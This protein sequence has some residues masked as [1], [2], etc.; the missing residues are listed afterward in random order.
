M[1]DSRWIE[2][3][4]YV[5][6]IMRR[7]HI[8]GAAVAV[9]REGEVLYK[10]GFGM[11]DMS[12]GAPV[13]PDTIFGI[14]SV[15]KSFTGLAIMRLQ[16]EGEL[17]SEDA[18]IRHL[19]DLRIRNMPDMR[20]VKVRHILS[21]TTGLSPVRRREEIT[22]FAEH[23]EYLAS[24]DCRIL[25]RPGDHFSYC[26]DTFMLNGALI[27]R[28]TGHRYR[29]HMMEALV[30]AF[31]LPRTTYD[32][33][34]L[35]SF[36]NVT[37]PYVYNK[38]TGQHEQK[39]YPSLGTYEVGGGVRSCVTALLRYGAL[40]VNGGVL[41]GERVLSE[42]ALRQMRSPVY[43]ISRKA[44]YC[45]ALETVPDYE[46][47]TLVFHGGSQPG[48]SAHFGFIPEKRLVAAVLTNVTGVPAKAI[49]LGAVNAALDLPVRQQY[50]TEPQYTATVAELERLAGS[51][52][53]D[54][55][56]KFVVAVE[57]GIPFIEVEGEPHR[58]RAS[59]E[60]TLVYE[61]NGFEAPVRFFF[62]DAGEVW[63]AR[64]GVRMHWKER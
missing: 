10:N 11:R 38:V 44:H 45:F 30:K 12:T 47:N 5:K 1:Q 32:I 37:V 64:L 4:D 19:P 31:G 53:N 29:A 22:T 6:E 42:A 20:A 39:A 25:G 63:A 2:F 57:A 55:G 28:V 27:E 7:T 24:F 49:W 14:G 36:D 16:D 9:S 34:E 46:G 15:S 21:H 62:N 43:Q 41:D 54:E 61:Q 52:G 59:D 33:T 35:P 26:N 56:G 48:V 23:T 51:F 18:V 40:Y 17:D 50:E 58:A 60:R 13:T 3:E 8:V